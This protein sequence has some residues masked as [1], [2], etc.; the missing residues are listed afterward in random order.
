MKKK[1]SKNTHG[2]A[3]RGQGKKPGI[4][5]KKNVKTIAVSDD[6]KD[7]M[8]TLGPTEADPSALSA[9]AVIESLIRKSPA[10]KK[11][12]STHP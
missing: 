7:Y 4:M 6:I 5:G 1:Q 8:A 12:K 11:W 10:F 9:S 2:G 3:G